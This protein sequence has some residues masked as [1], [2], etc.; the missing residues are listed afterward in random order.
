MHWQSFNSLTLKRGT[1]NTFLLTKK[2]NRSV[3]SNPTVCCLIYQLSPPFLGSVKWDKAMKRPTDF[4]DAL[5]SKMEMK[6]IVCL[7]TTM[8]RDD[9]L[10][11][12]LVKL[13][14]QELIFGKATKIL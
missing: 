11:V 13:Q 10:T 9:V 4:L 3:P 12:G 2:Q 8:V 7:E 6:G 1:E 14:D 5:H